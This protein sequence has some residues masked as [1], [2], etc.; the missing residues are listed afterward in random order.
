[1]LLPVTRWC[2][3][4][5]KTQQRNLFAFG[6]GEGIAGT[7][8]KFYRQG[9]DPSQSTILDDRNLVLVVGDIISAEN[10]HDAISDSRTG[11]ISASLKLEHEFNVGQISLNFFCGTLLECLYHTRKVAPIPKKCKKYQRSLKIQR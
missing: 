8:F 11:L 7:Q 3:R 9:S 4:R 2:S 1:M 10:E 6:G 5:A